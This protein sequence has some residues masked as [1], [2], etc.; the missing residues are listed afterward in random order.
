[1][2]EIVHGS[3]ASAD[4]GESVARGLQ[5]VAF[6]QEAQRREDAYQLEKEL[7]GAQV[8]LAQQRLALN[9]EAAAQQRDRDLFDRRLAL[10]G[11]G[12][13]E[14][15]EQRQA[16][17]ATRRERALDL[18]IGAYERA[19]DQDEAAQAFYA[20]EAAGADPATMRPALEAAG[21][22]LGGGLR[23][24]M[25]VAA[26]M[27]PARREL[28]AR[29]SPASQ[30]QFLQEEAQF[31]QEA[32]IEMAIRMIPEQ[33][34]HLEGLGALDAN[35][36]TALRERL[37]TAD[38]TEEL[39]ALGAEVEAAGERAWRR[40]A[41]DNS[42][43]TLLAQMDQQRARMMTA[44]EAVGGTYGLEE[45]NSTVDDIQRQLK[46][47]DELRNRV[48]YDAAPNLEAYQEDFRSLIR[49]LSASQG[50][51]PPGGMPAR[52]P[53]QPFDFGPGGG[54]AEAVPLRFDVWA[55]EGNVSD[56][57]VDE[58][59]SLYQQIEDSELDAESKLDQLER[60][61]GPMGFDP[62]SEVFQRMLDE[63]REEVRREAALAEGRAQRERLI[64]P[65]GIDR[66]STG[67]KY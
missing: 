38:T 17:E 37:A 45:Q 42:R 64:L 49:G 24:G 26:E 59:V 32:R 16:R 14:A 29:M 31:Q 3:R 63:K 12:I 57:R 27:T 66:R 28:F 47:L 55:A 21:A 8:N 7:A 41:L 22:V 4:G 36:A 34:R 58:I 10:R 19:R 61:F 23:E 11:M 39:V 6:L 52:V 1:M 54:A 56:E 67:R 50:A 51:V 18:E 53:T 20:L 9:E 43:Q 48:I 46:K 15:R 5:T 65:S 60:L 35:T 33:I 30:A 2:L 25:R 40:D 44:M 62:D 13:E